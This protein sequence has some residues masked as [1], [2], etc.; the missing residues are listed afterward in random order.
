MATLREA[1]QGQL[2]QL[3]AKAEQVDSGEL[4]GIHQACREPVLQSIS[5][6]FCRW[7]GTFTVAED[8]RRND[9]P[10]QFP[11]PDF[12]AMNS[13][14]LAGML[15][16]SRTL[17]RNS[18]SARGEDFLWCLFD[19]ITATVVARLV[20]AEDRRHIAKMN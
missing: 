8:L 6:D 4:A 5:E 7:L 3:R 18:V 1:L 13:A 15:I 19:I 10:H 2:D 16:A 12:R 17:A 9:Q 20:D 11:A 14:E